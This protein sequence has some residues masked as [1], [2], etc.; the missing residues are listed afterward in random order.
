MPAPF[1]R[2]TL[3][4]FAQVLERFPFTRTVNAVHMH[5]TWR[6]DHSQFRGHDSIVSMWRHHTAVNGWSDIAQHITIAPDG[7]IWLGRNWNLPPAS[8]SGHNGNLTCGPFMFEVVGDFD[9]YHDKLEGEQRRSVIEV[10]ARV[11]RRFGLAPASLMFHS[12]MSGKSCPGT[13]IAR[14]DILAEVAAAAQ[15]VAREGPRAAPEG[16][17]AA[18]ALEIHEI[19]ERSIALL[20]RP[21]DYREPG[22]AEVDHSDAAMREAAP[23][24]PAAR[25]S[26]LGPAALDALRPHLVNLNMGQLSSEGVA[27]TTEGDVDAIFE[28]HLP[29]AAAAAQAAGQK[30]R[31]VLYA[32]GGL[33]SESD[34]LKIAHK[35]V[36]WWMENHVYPIYFVWETGAYETIGQLIRRGAERTARALERDIF[37]HTTDLL[38]EETARVLQG[39]R[40][41]GG[42]KLSA[43][44]ACS[45]GGDGAA[46]REGGAHYVA[47]HLAQFCKAQGSKIELHAVGHSAGSIF[48]THFIPAALA[49]GTPAFKTAH[50]MAPAVR[51]DVFKSQL[52]DRVGSG[53]E[54]L[55]L[56]T[57]S[58]S[59]EQDDNCAAVY[60]KSLLYLIYHALEPDR[61]TPI[62]GLEA[63]LRGDEALK[64]AFGL[65]G[66]PARGDVVWSV[67]PAPAGRS[68]STSTTH[69]GFDDDPATM[70]SIVRRITGKDDADRIVEY[71]ADALRA[72]RD[73]WADAVDWPQA[74]WLTVEPTP[75]APKP[76]PAPQAT[77][78]AAAVIAG[79]AQ[80]A[81]RRR[82]L[83]VGINRYPTAPLHGCVADATLWASTLQGLG[84][85]APVTLFDERATL[86][87]IT[88]ALAELVETSRAGDVIVFQYAGHGTQLPDIDGDEAGG[89]TPGKDEAICPYDFAAGA[90]LI[91]DDIGQIFGRV[92]RGVNLTCFID[93]CHS[94][95]IS[96]FA[97]GR[98]T[99]ASSRPDE[100]P[101]F[102]VATPQMIEAHRQYRARFGVSRGSSAGSGGLTRMREVLFT[103]CLSSEV[104]WESGGQGDFTRR[105]IP[106]LR[107]GAGRVTHREFEQQVIAAFGTSPRQHARLY[108]DPACEHNI[109]LS[110]AAEAAGERTTVARVDDTGVALGQ[111]VEVL[112]KEV[113]KQAQ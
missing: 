109:L 48:H 23:G 80:P 4:A 28:Q 70:N 51:C 11:Q 84:F 39:P 99:A 104:A 61:K 9:R 10:I 22:D 19:L 96:R 113:Q 95:T 66:E 54:Q 17:F 55:T 36:A 89:D 34:G 105:A 7:G 77:A 50:F 65:T 41:W 25:D 32:H 57:M 111:R 102:L 21:V 97:V 26:G 107:N 69:G 24:E 53:V 63:S 8:A 112:L 90:F 67:S 82:A 73:P 62:L 93:C 5:H 75:A 101:R 31:V 58:R 46:A 88:E 78:P 85:E 2:L 37:D 15:A 87:G 6:P 92:P 16:P 81:G 20:S 3:E 49:A 45:S 74:L 94:G 108:C 60:R 86:E 56:Y 18:D 43:L 83:C 79:A 64:R 59:Y 1:K 72:A 110:P 12:A 29:K 106:V 71:R 42:M 47:R 91:D 44:I 100:R 38:I 33:V 14:D 30:L 35:H 98:P 68:A 103:A 52:L 40:I 13:G 27:K 76:P